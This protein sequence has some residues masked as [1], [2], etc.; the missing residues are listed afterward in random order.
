MR[1]RCTNNSGKA[2]PARLRNI[3]LGFTEGTRFHLT[4]GTEYVVYALTIFLGDIWYYICDDSYSYYPVWNPAVLFAISDDRISRFWKIGYRSKD[5]SSDGGFLLAFPEWAS[6]PG[7]YE[8][9]TD[10][11]AAAVDLFRH[12]K[13]VM[14]QEC[15][16]DSKELDSSKR[17]ALRK[18]N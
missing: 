4:L 11:D 3:E 7:Y 9:L 1:V 5:E 12:Y 15:G 18:E 17:I 16:S 13:E 8:R 2:L 6:D 10:G 14:D